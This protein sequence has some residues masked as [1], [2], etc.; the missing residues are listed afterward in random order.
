MSATPKNMNTKVYEIVTER[1][2][3]ALEKGTAP[4]RKPWAGGGSVSSC[5]PVNL[6]SRRPYRGVNVWLLH[7][8]GF[9]SRYWVTFNQARKL[10]GNVRKGEKGSLVVFWK[11]L[12]GKVVDGVK[13]RD[14]LMIRYSTVFNL[15]QCDGLTDP[16]ASLA[17]AVAKPEP[18]AI[19]SA[20]A[21]A[22]AMPQAPTLTH[23]GGRACYSP[24]LDVVRM[25]ERAAFAKQPEYYSTLFHELIHATGHESRVGREFGLSFGSEKYSREELVAEMGAAFLCAEAGIVDETLDNSAAYLASWISRLKEDPTLVVKAASAA[26]KAAEFILAREAQAAPVAVPVAPEGD[27]GDDDSA[28]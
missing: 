25:P 20:Q 1:I 8:S 13:S 16:D 19:A 15:S 26:Q 5:G 11:K 9:S 17:P 6:A 21:I 24:S 10:K 18:E 14:F 27:E 4:W 12:P 28:E 2:V 23:G 7:A 3:A 22:D